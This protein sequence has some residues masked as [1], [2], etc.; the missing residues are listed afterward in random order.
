MRD[1]NDEDRKIMCDMIRK[2]TG[3]EAVAIVV[4]DSYIPCPDSM[5][6]DGCAHA[7]QVIF[8]V[9]GFTPNGL[10]E[11]LHTTT[12]AHLKEEEGEE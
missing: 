10:V 6:G 9:E 3:A 7:H 12:G 5:A 11:V 2:Y 8:A 1:I 4:A